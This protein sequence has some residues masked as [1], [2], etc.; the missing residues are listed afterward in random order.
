[1]RVVIGRVRFCVRGI[2]HFGRVA[3][4]PDGVDVFVPLCEETVYKRVRLPRAWLD[5]TDA[6]VDCMSCLVEEARRTR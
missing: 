3:G 5:T 6:P 2:V 4:M 1:M